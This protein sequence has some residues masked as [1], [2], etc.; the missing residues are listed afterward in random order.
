MS[1]IEYVWKTISENQSDP[2]NRVT[3]WFKSIID[4][5]NPIIKK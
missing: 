5:Q 4:I 3:E 1:L 2:E